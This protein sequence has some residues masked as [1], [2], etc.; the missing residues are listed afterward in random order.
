MNPLLKPA[1]AY[2]L[3]YEFGLERIDRYDPDSGTTRSRPVQ[4]YH[5]YRQTFMLEYKSGGH[6]AD[7][8]YNNKKVLETMQTFLTQVMKGMGPI[9]AKEIISSFKQSD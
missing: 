8:Y 3:L 7:R 2:W 4:K 6:Y 9:W 5:R 1:V